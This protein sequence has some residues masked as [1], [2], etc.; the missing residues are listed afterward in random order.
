MNTRNKILLLFLASV[1]IAALVLFSFWKA[2]QNQNNFIIKEALKQQEVLV[3]TA[4]NVQSNQL[5]QLVLDYTNWDELVQNMGKPNLRWANDNIASI[6]NSFKLSNVSIYGTDNQL[7]YGFGIRSTDILK[8]NVAKEQILEKIRVKGK[9]H[10][11]QLSEEGIFEI[12]ASSIF[13]TSDT[14]RIGASPGIFMISKKWDRTFINDLSRNTASSIFLNER[15]TR[16]KSFI[17]NDS[18]TI[19]IDLKG[20]D[21]HLVM[22]L[23]VKKPNYV[24]VNFQKVSN[25]MFIFLIILMISLLIVF[26]IILYR[27]V[28]RPLQ[29]ISDSLSNNDTSQLEILEKDKNEFSQIARLINIFHLQKQQLEKENREVNQMQ[30]ELIKQSNV[31]HGMALASNH[32]LTNN[33]FESAIHDALQSVSESTNIDRIFIYKADANLS[34]KTRKVI[35]VN[36]YIAPEIQPM[37]DSSEAEEIYVNAESILWYAHLRE[38]KTI[39]GSTSTFDNEI[40]KLLE[41][42]QIKTLMLFPIIDQKQQNLW[43][44]VGFAQCHVEHLWTNSEETLLGMLSY[45]IAGAILRQQN[46]MALSDALEMAKSADRAKSEFLASMSHE[47]RTPM[48]GVIGM[49]SL[50]QLTD[51]TETQ[52]DYINIIETSGESLMNIINEILDFSKIETGHMLLEENSFDLRLCI[53]DVLDLMAPKALEKHLDIIYYIDPMI[54]QFIFGDGFRLRQII[55]NLVSNAIKF[56]EKGEILIYIS[57]L[58]QKGGKVELEFSVK[59]TGIGIPSNKI[60]MLFSPFTQVDASTTRKYG[61][62][63]LGLAITSSLVKLMKGKIWVTSQE[64]VGSDFRFTIQTRF[65]ATSEEINPVQQSLR[66]LVKRSVLIVDDNATNLKILTLQCELWGLTVTSCQSGQE[67]LNCL[68]SQQFDAAILDMQ[69][70]E[71][72]GVMLAREIRLTHSIAALPLIMLTS[73]G[74]NTDSAELKQLFSFYV[75][76]PIKHTQLSEI[77]LKIL[78]P[79]KAEPV[80]PKKSK[81]ELSEISKRFPFQI[82]VAEDNIINQKL[83]K[84]VFDLLGYKMDIAANGIE[85]LEALKRKQ[86]DLIFMDI[87][88]PEMNGYEATEIIIQKNLIHRPVIIAMTANAMPGDR[89]KCMEAGMDDYITKPM[90]VDDLIH[91]IEHWGIKKEREA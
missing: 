29:I 35:R 77:L 72:D 55:V 10:F 39:K 76:K 28:R 7:V 81:E 37:V 64:G 5:D 46:Q 91:V 17:E 52:R 65:S 26:F 1:I 63:G 40:R 90:K 21:D 38:G 16:Q 45:N 84:N 19:S 82:L 69:M 83:I 43:G 13:N 68:K 71:M 86:Y 80:M 59:D 85:A 44:I 2:Q 20:Y 57:L 8:E 79:S 18:I 30:E 67:A 49:T 87:Q 4:L 50:L 31:L 88:M 56:T 32:L 47:I 36:E 41:R 12:A 27:W 33:D 89:E 6:V 74:Y 22:N 51:L 9:L 78:S 54:H 66:N 42:Q 25:F 75:Y 70:P 58:S 48:N 34:G 60:E 23:A 15:V 61:G 73:V 14:A 24:L 62:T 11:F 3:N 53:E